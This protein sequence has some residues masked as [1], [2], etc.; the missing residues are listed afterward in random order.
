MTCII[1]NGYA[2]RGTLLCIATFVEGILHAVT[3]ID[4]YLY[5]EGKFDLM[6][7]R[8][9]VKRKQSRQIHYR[10]E[11][12]PFF[13]QCNAPPR[14]IWARGH[15]PFWNS[16][17]QL[18]FAVVMS[19]I[20]YFSERVQAPSKDAVRQMCAG[21]FPSGAP[22]SRR[23]ADSTAGTL[24]VSSAEAKQVGSSQ[25]ILV[26]STKAIWNLNC[27]HHLPEAVT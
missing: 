13:L 2:N 27:I 20:F 15:N 24:S 17:K 25:R 5:I 23:L 14:A 6:F 1:Q 3:Q 18:F 8:L 4:T 11:I 12:V 16:S 10:Y 22:E 9:L 19:N 26:I 7:N 21:S